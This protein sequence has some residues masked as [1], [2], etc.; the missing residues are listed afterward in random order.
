MNP[1]K[2]NFEDSFL[3]QAQD[4][5]FSATAGFVL[6][7]CAIVYF[8]IVFAIFTRKGDKVEKIVN[9]KKSRQRQ[10]AFNGPIEPNVVE[11]EAKEPSVSKQQVLVK[12]ES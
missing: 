2:Q 3:K 6:M 5:F 7:L 11:V 8:V 1:T 10:V 4:S 12:K 9:S